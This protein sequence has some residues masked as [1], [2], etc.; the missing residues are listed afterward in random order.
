VS[1]ASPRFESGVWVTT[2]EILSTVPNPQVL[3][4]FT[5]EAENTPLGA[6]RLVRYGY[7][8]KA[9]KIGK[10]GTFSSKPES[11]FPDRTHF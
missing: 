8:E 6:S 5:G 4:E 9:K 2:L 10:G 3:I 7:D 1:E 11:L